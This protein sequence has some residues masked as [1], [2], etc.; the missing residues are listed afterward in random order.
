MTTLSIHDLRVRLPRRCTIYAIRETIA[1]QGTRQGIRLMGP[2]MADITATVAATLGLSLD[3]DGYIFVRT[4]GPRDHG[5][6]FV[7][8]QIGKRLYGRADALTVHVADATR[9]RLT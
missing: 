3:G 5:G 7:I 6:R 9:R 1:D 8:E 2:D 4:A